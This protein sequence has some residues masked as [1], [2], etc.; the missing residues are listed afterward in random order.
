MSRPTQFDNTAFQN[1]PPV[2]EEYLQGPRA[3]TTTL[4]RSDPTP[5][6]TGQAKQPEQGSD[7]TVEWV[8]I[9]IMFFLTCICIASAVLFILS[10][11]SGS[12]TTTPGSDVTSMAMKVPQVVAKGVDRM[13]A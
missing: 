2:F 8:V 1:D 9:S 7:Q 4:D 6:L 3:S 13:V 5:P 12:S 10:M 11:T